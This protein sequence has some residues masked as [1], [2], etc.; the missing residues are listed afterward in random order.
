MEKEEWQKNEW[1]WRIGRLHP[2][3]FHPRKFH[4]LAPLEPNIRM[5]TPTIFA[6]LGAHSI[7]TLSRIASQPQNLTQ[8]L[9][10][11]ETRKGIAYPFYAVIYMFV[12]LLYNWMVTLAC[13]SFICNSILYKFFCTYQPDRLLFGL[14]I[15][16]L[17][18]AQ[19]A[20]GLIPLVASQSVTVGFVTACCVHICNRDSEP[21]STMA[22]V[23]LKNKK[24]IAGGFVCSPASY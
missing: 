14:V 9:P 24:L 22:R 6:R 16:S 18:R 12:H 5:D 11:L 17:L 15:N 4:P 1:D 13:S 2:P 10:N 21:R 20:N 8:K 19:D 23:K 3:L 7:R